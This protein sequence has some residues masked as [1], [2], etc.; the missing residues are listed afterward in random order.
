MFASTSGA[1]ETIAAALQSL[2]IKTTNKP[3]NQFFFPEDILAF[4]E[5]LYFMPSG[6]VLL[7]RICLHPLEEPQKQSRQ[8]YKVSM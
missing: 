7:P 4:H 2:Y 6:N 1:T 3:G 5:I 8:H